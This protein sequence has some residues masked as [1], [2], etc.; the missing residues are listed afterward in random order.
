M[1]MGSDTVHPTVK[2]SLSS[3]SDEGENP[4]KHVDCKNYDISSCFV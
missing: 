2:F 3:I 4:Q 1:E